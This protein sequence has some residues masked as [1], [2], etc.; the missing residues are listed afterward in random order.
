MDD[1]IKVWNMGIYLKEKDILRYCRDIRWMMVAVMDVI[2][3]II[4][5]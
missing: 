3:G 5:M 4:Q 2:L 1:L